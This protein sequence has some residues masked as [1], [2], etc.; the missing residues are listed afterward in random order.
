MLN[1]VGVLTAL[2]CCCFQNLDQI[3]IIINNRPNDLHLDFTPNVDLKD[4]FK[5][6]VGLVEDS[7]EL[8]EKVKYFEELHIDKD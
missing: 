3:I 4:Y 2:R 5:T 6:K 1:L 7:Y 8:I